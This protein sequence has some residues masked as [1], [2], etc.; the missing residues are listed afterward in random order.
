MT[1]SRTSWEFFFILF[2]PINYN[3]KVKN[4]YN[5]STWFG[6]WP[7]IW[8]LKLPKCFS[9]R[10]L[11]LLRIFLPVKRIPFLSY[12][13]IIVSSYTIINSRQSALHLAVLNNHEC[14]LLALVEH[15]KFVEKG[16][17]PA[18]DRSNTSL[19]PNLNLKNSEGDTPASLALTEGKIYFHK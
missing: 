10:I 5:P 2:L 15:R 1:I 14:A 9:R 3:G 12:F 18:T 16:E 13:C 7:N 6:S 19:V 8:F 17:F 11:N 4:V